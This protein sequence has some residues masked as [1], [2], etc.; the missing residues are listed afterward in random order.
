[1]AIF[2]LKLA[3]VKRKTE[4][5]PKA[6]P[7]CQG[8][9]FQRWGKTS[10]PIRD[11]R[12]RRVQVYRYRCCRCKRTFRHYPEGISRAAQTKRLQA[13]AVLCWVYLE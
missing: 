3:S 7:Y 2:V 8:E 10:K 12:C 1:M 9:T 6:C 11:I 5:R 4:L 13:L